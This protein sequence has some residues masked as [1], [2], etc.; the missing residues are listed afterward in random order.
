MYNY[1]DFNGDGFLD[2]MAVMDDYNGDGV[3]DGVSYYTDSNYDGYY[4]QISSVGD[5]NNDGFV[6][7]FVSQ[8]DTD[9]DGYMETTEKMYDYDQDGFYDSR[10]TYQDWNYDG[11]AEVVTDEYT[12]KDGVHTFE[13]NVDSNSDG[14]TDESYQEQRMDFDGDGFEES[15]YMEMDYDGDGNPDSSGYFYID[16]LSNEYYPVESWGAIPSSS[17]VELDNFDPS[18]S[19]P[20]LVAGN[21]AASMD[22]WEFQGD[23]Q[24]CALYS[25][26]FVIEELTGKDIPIED[27][28]D[29]AS[30]NGWFSEDSGTASLNMTKVLEAYGIENE[31]SFHND[32]DDIKNC[33]E[34]GGKVIVS[35]DSDQVWY[36]E[37]SNLFSPADA[38]NHAVEVIGIDY[39]NPDEP[40][41]ILND[42]GSPNGCGEMI[43]LDVFED[44]WAAGDKQMV[45]CYA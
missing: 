26:K 5:T 29:L 2:T 15:S 8:Y 17:L 21:P 43:A 12:D 35:I 1:F 28:V 37:D 27:I 24:R 22:E 40:M 39:S 45:E 31:M 32:V 19:D 33:L 25:Q 4:E 18:Q 11:Q 6:D 20:E 3:I 44:A 41:V 34:N 30:E 16:P 36:G 14:F 9:G 13:T 7:A 42:S 38:A 10:K 23:T